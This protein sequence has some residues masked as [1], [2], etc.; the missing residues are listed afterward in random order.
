MINCLV[1]N[2]G[3]RTTGRSRREPTVTINLEHIIQFH[4]SVHTLLFTRLATISA[5][6]CIL[7]HITNETL[8]PMRFFSFFSLITLY[9]IDN[10]I[11]SIYCMRQRIFRRRVCIGKVIWGRNPN[12]RFTTHKIKQLG[13]LLSANVLLRCF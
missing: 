10:L 9:F 2:R 1:V 3:G 5:A 8:L 4:N 11:V 12:F 6:S 13:M 7:N